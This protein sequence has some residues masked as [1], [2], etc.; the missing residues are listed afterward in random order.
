MTSMKK[1]QNQ[2]ITHKIG[3]SRD[4]RIS[5]SSDKKAYVIIS[6]SENHFI[7]SLDICNIVKLGISK[8]GEKKSQE[9]I[10]L[11]SQTKEF[12]LETINIY[13][14]IFLE[15]LPN[16]WKLWRKNKLINSIN[17]DYNITENAVDECIDIP[18]ITQNI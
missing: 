3:L 4:I 18:D 13:I 10:I 12:N 2:N 15:V 1:T 17:N 14:S 8:S 9:L 7:S 6:S 5:N 16:T 11:P